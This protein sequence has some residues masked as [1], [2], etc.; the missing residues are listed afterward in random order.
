VATKSPV[1]P[2]CLDCQRYTDRFEHFAFQQLLPDVS[3]RG[4]IADTLQHFAENQISQPEALAVSF[5]VQPIGLR[6]LQP[7]EVI[8]P[9]RRVYD[10]HA[11]IPRRAPAGKC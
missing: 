5:L 11:V 8:D 4:L 7:P 2:C 3:C 6:V 1:I 10:Y 9:H